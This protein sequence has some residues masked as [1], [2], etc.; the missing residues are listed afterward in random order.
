MDMATSKIK[1]RIVLRPTTATT[2]ASGQF[3]PSLNDGE[4]LIGM[5]AGGGLYGFVRL[6]SGGGPDMLQLAT[7]N[8]STGQFVNF[9]NRT[10]EVELILLV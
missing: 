3:T 1:P 10:Y 8:P 9:A 5:R 7:Y 4:K 2:D 6:S